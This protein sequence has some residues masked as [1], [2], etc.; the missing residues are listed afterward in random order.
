MVP[1][2]EIVG[3]KWSLGEYIRLNGGTVNRSKKVWGILVEE[4]DEDEEFVSDLCTACNIDGC[5]CYIIYALL[6]S[7]K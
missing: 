7:S 1:E 6:Y 3:K 4:D 5:K 2:T